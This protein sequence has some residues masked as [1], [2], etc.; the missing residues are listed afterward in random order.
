MAD[1]VYLGFGQSSG[2]DNRSITQVIGQ[3]VALSFADVVRTGL[4]GP[5]IPGAREPQTNF[6]EIPGGPVEVEFEGINAF[7]SPDPTA[8]PEIK[9]IVAPR[10]GGQVVGQ[11]FTFDQ[12]SVEIGPLPPGNAPEVTFSEGGSIPPLS[13]SPQ[14]SA[15]VSAIMRPFSFSGS[16]TVITIPPGS[17]RQLTLDFPNHFFQMT[18]TGAVPIKGMRVQFLD[19][20]FV[21]PALRGQTREIVSPPSSGGSAGAVFDTLVLDSAITGLG[22]L[23]AV[24]NYFLLTGKILVRLTPVEEVILG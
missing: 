3:E 19:A 17:L 15:P 24:N 7:D 6:N 21:D 13:L 12:L 20:A 11:V 22:A 4:G 5:I 2:F 14:R 9:F 23:G 8:S 1:V 18:E 16:D 10:Q